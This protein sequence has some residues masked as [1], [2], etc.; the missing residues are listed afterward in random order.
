MRIWRAPWDGTV[1]MRTAFEEQLVEAAAY[2][3]DQDG[4]VRVHF[5]IAHTSKKAFEE[6]IRAIKAKCRA[7]GVDF[8]ISLSVQ[9]PSTDT[10]AVDT[11]NQPF[12]D[13]EGRLLFR[14]GGHGALLANL[15]NLQADIVFIK[16][17]DNVTVD[18]HREATVRFKKALGVYLVRLQEAIFGYLRRLSGP[19]RS[20][21]LMA[22]IVEFIQK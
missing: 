12:R 6:L 3:R 22:E 1:M 11:A 19:N 15:N 4:V 14:P 7:T 20:E 8:S 13:R 21:A 17:I 5:T 9:E 2:I 16:N 18:T 10:I